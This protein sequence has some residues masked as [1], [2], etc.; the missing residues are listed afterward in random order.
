[1]QGLVWRCWRWLAA[2][3]E[4]MAR[5]VG[6]RGELCVAPSDGRVLLGGGF[7]IGVSCPELRRIR[8]SLLSVS[9]AVTRI[10]DAVQTREEGYHDVEEGRRV[11]RRMRLTVAA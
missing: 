9:S 7:D 11:A 6:G 10:I 8:L 2:A 5:S 1:M 4:F 3:V